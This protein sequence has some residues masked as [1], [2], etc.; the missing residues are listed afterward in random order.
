MSELSQVLKEPVPDSVL[1]F[2]C[3]TP[4]AQRGTGYYGLCIAEVANLM[5]A[6]GKPPWIFSAA[7][8]HGSLRGI[9]KSGF[10]PRFSL[11]RRKRF[12]LTTISTS[13]LKEGPASQFDLYPA[14]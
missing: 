10:I 8:N 14:A 12:L 9:E 11:K 4:S 13:E 6:Q 5:L 3:W 7:S 1:L 2:D